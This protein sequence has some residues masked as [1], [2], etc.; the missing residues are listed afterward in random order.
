MVERRIVWSE[1]E[2]KLLSKVKSLQVESSCSHLRFGSRNVQR[3]LW[4]GGRKEGGNQ[5]Q[6]PTTQRPKALLTVINE[7]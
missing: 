7:D 3:K 1:R 4:K 6:Q 5:A 2:T